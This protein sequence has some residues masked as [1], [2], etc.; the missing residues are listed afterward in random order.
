MNGVGGFCPKKDIIFLFLNLNGNCW[1]ENLRDSLIHEFAHSVSDYYLGGENFNLGEGLIFDGLAEHFRKR[2]FG[3]NDLLIKSISEE[4]SEK[5]LEELK[6]RLESKDFDLYMEVFYGD[7]KY[8]LWTGYVIGYYLVGKYLSKLNSFDWNE[9][10]RKN[11][12]DILKK[13]IN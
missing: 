10:L 2:N 9:L 6:D 7:G 11:P 8:P 12:R 4:D 13:V 3:G 5:Y 1:K